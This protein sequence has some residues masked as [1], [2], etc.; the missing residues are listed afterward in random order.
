MRS[1]GAVILI[2]VAALILTA[3]DLLSNGG[4]A[5][6]AP[7]PTATADQTIT[8]VTAPDLPDVTFPITPTQEASTLRIWLPPLI[9]ER[10]EEGA[11]TLSDQISLFDQVEPLLK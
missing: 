6:V 1:T 10:T 5:D 2:F 3:C 4:E 8:T 11:R 7:E 9:A